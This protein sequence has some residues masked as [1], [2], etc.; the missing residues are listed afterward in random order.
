MRLSILCAVV[1]VVAVWRWRVQSPPDV[2]LIQPTVTTIT[3]TITSSGRVHGV[4][5]TVVGA[6]T[7]GIVDQLF[8]AEGDRVTAGQPIAVLKHEVAEARVAQAEQA[9]KTARA[10]VAQLQAMP[11]PSDVE[12]AVQ[13]VHQAQ[14][15][16]A[17]QRAA[18]QQA[19]QSV[20]QSRAQLHQLQAEMDLAATQLE[21]SEAL[22]ERDYIARAEVDQARTQFR[23]AERR[24]A[25]AQQAVE[26]AQANVQALEAAGQAAQANVRSLEARLRTIRIGATPEEID[27]A[28]QRVADAEHALQVAREQLAEA[29]V[30]APFAGTVTAINAEPGQP[31]GS[32]GVIRLVSSALEIRLD[33]DE[34]N[35]ADL[36]VGQEAVMSS[37]AFPGQTFRGD[38]T[39]IG[40]AV[41][42]ARGTV[43]VKAMPRQPPDWLRPGQ[44]VN[45]N[46]ITHRAVLRLLVP[47]EAI[48]RSDNQTVVFVV[49]N[50]RALEKVV[51]TRAPTA[52]GVPVLAGV[53]PEDRII[54][55][56]RGLA[57]G[58]GVR[59][60]D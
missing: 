4:T 20:A 60:R 3:E 21:R 40:A 12:A 36:A 22:F 45:V 39:E 9:I 56:V 6:Q 57:A 28:L 49:Q 19:Q 8:V 42:S 52:Q 17:Q 29:T 33:V 50:G 25:A 23:V 2:S 10:Q 35:L 14:A 44:T 38:V 7:A 13:Q 26:A 16:L 15:Q 18:M 41:D 58:Q 30:A 32:L 31:V 5:E 46:V 1:L 37:S 54:A 59:V 43:T 11:L 55:D 48:G 47:R 34:S 24:V 51:I 53:T 27:V